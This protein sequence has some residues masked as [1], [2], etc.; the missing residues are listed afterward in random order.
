MAQAKTQD[1][2]LHEYHWPSFRQAEISEL[3]LP[4]LQTASWPG[5][6]TWYKIART[7]SS[8]RDTT[9]PATCVSS[10]WRKIP[11]PISGATLESQAGR[12]AVLPQPLL[13][14]RTGSQR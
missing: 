8:G 5:S 1:T 7:K 14:T 9:T 6:L 12:M 10:P 4:I 3:A 11:T 13:I 2:W